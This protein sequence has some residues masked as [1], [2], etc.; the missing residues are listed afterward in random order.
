MAA[1]RTVDSDL[2]DRAVLDEVADRTRSDRVGQH[3]V[4]GVHRE[5]H[6]PGVGMIVADPPRRLDSVDLRHRDVHEHHIGVQLVEEADRLL[7]VGSLADHV[8]ALLD[9]RPAKA[10]AKHLVV[11]DEHQPDALAAGAS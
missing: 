5:H 9:H 1:W 8:E 7:A 2:V 11:V 4:I 6:D 3:R 10:L